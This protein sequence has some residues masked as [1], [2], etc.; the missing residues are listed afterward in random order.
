[1]YNSPLLKEEAE[2]F[3]ENNPDGKKYAFVKAYLMGLDYIR[4][5]EQR[6]KRMSALAMDDLDDP[7]L[8]LEFVDNLV[9]EN[10]NLRVAKNLIKKFET[11]DNGLIL[12]CVDLFIKACEEQ[13]DINKKEQNLFKDFY[14]LHSTGKVKF[15]DKK[16]FINQFLAFEAQ[17]KDSL[18]MFLEA[19]V[20]VSKILVSDQEDQ[21]GN[22]KKLGIT[23]A[24]RDKLL[25]RVDE[26]YGEGYEGSV[27]QGQSFLQASISVIREVLEDYRF[28]SLDD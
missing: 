28:N 2:K 3:K 14:E 22:L 17:R 20:L 1:M 9:K 11:P 13:V 21:F 27:R 5:N 26:F 18:K 24:Q 16:A 7:D 10:M 8:V 19:S 15:D 6:N 12:L 25:F 23:D 4:K